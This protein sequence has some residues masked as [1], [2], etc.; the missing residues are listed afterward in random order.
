MTVA[1]EKFDHRIEKLERYA[2]KHPN[3]YKLRLRLL[4]ILGYSYIFLITFVLLALIILL[5]ALLVY[6]RTV[7][8]GMIK[9]II[10]LAIPTFAIARSLWVTFPPPKGI[11]LHRRQVPQLFTLI[12]RLTKTLKAPHF[13]RVLL[14]NDFNAAVAQIPRLGILGWQQNYLI[15]G[16]PLLYALSPDQFRAVLAHEFGHLS[17]NHSR[18]GGWIYRMRQTWQQLWQQLHESES[19][20]AIALFE[21]FL[22]WYA[23]Y[24]SAYS[25]VLARSNEY[26]A[27]RCAAQVAGSRH[28][29]EALINVEVKGAFVEESFWTEIYQQTSEQ[30]DPPATPFQSLATALACEIDPTQEQQ[31]LQTAL[32]QKTD[33]TD[34]HPCLSE[35]LQALG[36]SR[37]PPVPKSVQRTAAQEFLGT[38]LTQL[39]QAL[40]EEWHTAVQFQ[41]RER[42][43]HVQNQRKSLKQLEAKAKDTPL[44]IEEAWNRAQLTLEID[45]E[46]A[47]LP[48]LKVVLQQE[49]DHTLA[50]YV[51]GQ[52]LI[53][54][55]DVRGVKYLERAMAQEANLVLNGC[56][57]LYAFWQSQNDSAKA[58]TYQRRAEKH[59]EMMLLA[60]QERAFAQGSDRFLAHALPSEEVAA[61][62]KQFARYPEIKE[63][64]CVRKV[65]QYFPE[66]PFYVLGIVRQVPWYKLESESAPQEFIARLAAEIEFSEE[67]WITIL[68][69]SD[70][71][72][73]KAFKKMAVAPI[74]S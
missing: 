29:A 41:W 25:F 17:G 66:K 51:L 71:A 23:P 4:V 5:V 9:L 62:R 56:E 53:A 18:F 59:Y 72:L 74:Y 50:N 61:L 43:T 21:R 3:L 10:F 34:T 24:F 40:E 26:E 31:W 22:N 32:E 38:A 45:G 11:T 42:Y 58:E 20:S 37:N 70:R 55:E 6:S 12:D 46:K 1:E 64:Y 63:A 27:D 39:T 8:A 68:N 2:Q 48:L 60:Q 44:T 35:R 16:L 36:Y 54:R 67:M 49:K 13:Q 57:L 33:N 19:A 14:T 28:A 52:I 65:V 47:A 73:Q 15:I 69:G 7:N 30:P